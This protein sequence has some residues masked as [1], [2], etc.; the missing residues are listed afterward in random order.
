MR[1]K[2]WIEKYRSSTWDNFIHPDKD[3]LKKMIETPS[4]M[5]HLLL[6]SSTPGTGKTT[7]AKLL[8]KLLGADYLILNSSSDRKIETIRDKIVGFASTKS[9]KKDMPKIVLMDELD[10]TP[11]LTQEALRNV[12]ETFSGN[13]KFIITANNLN[14]IHEAVQSRCVRL[15]FTQPDKADIYKHLETICSSEGLVF[16]E[17]GLNKIVD[18]HYPSIRNMINHLQDLSI[19]SKAVKIENIKKFGEEFDDL[20]NKIKEGKF[21]E[22]KTYILQNNVNVRALNKHIWTDVLNMDLTAKVA[23]IMTQLAENEYRFSVGAENN[24]IF[25]TSLIK[26]IG[27]WRK[28]E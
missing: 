24:I 22:A 8:I 11:K 19:Q 10:G 9:M 15:E 20:W 6:V 3:K 12:M 26:I 27:L 4:S 16:D 14:K 17:T 28:K 1:E 13:C 5:P 7:L 18:I 23:A 21:T 2:V 25:I